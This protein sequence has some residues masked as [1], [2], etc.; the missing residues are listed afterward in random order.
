M[1]KVG[2]PGPTLYPVSASRAPRPVR[3]DLTA[4]CVDGCMFSVMVG[5]GETYF[6]A[7][8]LALGI[9]KVT[10]GLVATVP[11]LLGA[12]MQLVSPWAVSKLRSNGRWVVGT[13]TAQ[14]LSLVPLI[15]AA[16]AGWIPTVALFA[17]L[18]VYFAAG[19]ASGP[20]WTTWIET[21][22]PSRI[23]SPYYAR[24][25]VWCQ[26]ALLA[27]LLAAGAVL[28]AADG[29]GGRVT[30]FA[31]LFVTAALARVVSVRCLAMQSEPVPQP[32]GERHHSMTDLLC[33]PAHRP[34]RR[35]FVFLL[36]SYAAMQVAVPFITSYLRGELRM[37]YAQFAVLLAIP[38]AA[39][40][41]ATPWLGRIAQR[42][43][44]RRLMWI[45][46]LALV[47]SAALWAVSSSFAWIAL[48]Q[49]VSGFAMAAFELANLLLWFETIP[50]QDRTSML[51]TYQFWYATAV[52]TGSVA[53]SLL[54]LAFG[55]G[56]DAFIV[57][58]L[59]SAA[60]RVLSLGLFAWS[61]RVAPAR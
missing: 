45:G 23:A 18:S 34:A 56:R 52:V 44:A 1:W 27:T 32:S 11:L 2:A 39:R 55:E 25:S 6:A 41:A 10:A 42:L 3:R 53:G 36:A 13:A 58:F 16:S 50:A 28:G 7:F 49:L 20:A 51:T 33:G 17:V 57:V 4:S 19:F 5:A 40:I 29:S 30:A 31:A 14:A 61:G 15:V 22:V 46:A 24:R 26:L 21:L 47:P 37:P 9:D 35:L 38:Y 48:V 54:L 60:A 8:A 59:A 43:G 12:A